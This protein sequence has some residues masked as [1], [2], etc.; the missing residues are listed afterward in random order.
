MQAPCY[1]RTR[2]EHR[3]RNSD[4]YEVNR[5][6]DTVSVRIYALGAQH[7]RVHRRQKRKVRG[8]MKY[9]LRHSQTTLQQLCALSFFI[10]PLISVC[11]HSACCRTRSEHRERNSDC[12]EVN[13][14]SDT[15]SVRIYALGAQH[16]RVHRRQK[17]KVRG[18]MKYRLRHSQT[19]L[20][21]L[22]ALSFFIYPL[23][24]VCKHP[25]IVDI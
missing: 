6:S 1:C 11:K 17:R 2:S 22:C 16:L 21:Q 18:G 13:R 4:C 3:K 12:Y 19:T 8:G 7:L 9:R 15:V 5:V 10:Y 25:A 24:S 14:V 20:Q 23:I